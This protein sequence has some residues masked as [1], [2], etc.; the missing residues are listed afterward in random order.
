MAAR[1]EILHD[2]GGAYPRACNPKGGGLGPLGLGAAIRTLGKWEISASQVLIGLVTCFM[3][4]ELA[5]ALH[6]PMP[7]IVPWCF[8]ALMGA[9]TVATYSITA[10]LFDN[11]VLGRVNAVINLCHIGCAFLMQSGI[12]LVLAQWHQ[13]EPG[14]YPAAAYSEALLAL[15]GITLDPR[16]P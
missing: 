2:G 12:G 6:V 4:S 5:L 14:R 1:A 7:L 10:V 16:A 13:T 8:V 9:E 15:L 11:S 3:G